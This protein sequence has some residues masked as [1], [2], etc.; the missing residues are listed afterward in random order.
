MSLSRTRHGFESR[1]GYCTH[2]AESTPS[3]LSLVK[4]YIMIFFGTRSKTF[5]GPVINN[6]RCGHCGQTVHATGGIQ[7]YFHI[8]WIPVIPM[9]RELITSC[10]HCKLVEYGDSLPKPLKKDIQQAVFQ[11][12]KVLL[13]FSGPLL[14]AL[15]F[16]A[17]FVF[18]LQAAG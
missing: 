18:S 16:T 13:L 8:Y 10:L 3:L 5:A 15:A 1:T 4:G 7:R 11:T 9:Y 14:I 6:L 12:S 2:I 17:L